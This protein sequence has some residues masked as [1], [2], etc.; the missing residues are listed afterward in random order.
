M[1]EGRGVGGTRGHDPE[2]CHTATTAPFTLGRGQ[3][4]GGGRGGGGWWGV[5]VQFALCSFSLQ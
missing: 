3:G 1:R 2:K 5:G 4:G